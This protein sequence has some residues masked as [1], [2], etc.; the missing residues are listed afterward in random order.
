MRWAWLATVPAVLAGAALA[1]EPPVVTPPAP[2]SAAQAA[3]APAPPPVIRLSPVQAETALKALKAADLHGLKPQAYLPADEGDP[4]ALVQGLLRYA[5]DVKVGRLQ[6]G[7]FP[8]LWA[9]RPA[10]YDPAPDMA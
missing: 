3:P 9:V 10:P 1:Q 8:D 5:R 4:A 7:D 2:P 6:P